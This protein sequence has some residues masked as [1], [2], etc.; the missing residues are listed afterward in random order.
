MSNQIRDFDGNPILYTCRTDRFETDIGRGMAHGSSSNVR[1]SVFAAPL[2]EYN[3][4]SLW[5]EHVKGK[6]EDGDLYWLM[7]Y[8]N[9][10]PETAGSAVF[11]KKNIQKMIELLIKLMP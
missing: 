7:R 5:L 2:D 1:G 11:W 9:G 6:D 4:H 8:R 10:I 3:G